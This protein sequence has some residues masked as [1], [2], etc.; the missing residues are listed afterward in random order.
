MIRDIDRY[1]PQSLLNQSNQFRSISHSHP[2]RDLKY[3]PY[4]PTRSMVGAAPPTMGRSSQRRRRR[5]AA[6]STSATT[7]ASTG[8]LLLLL[9]CLAWAPALPTGT[10]APLLKQ[11]LCIRLDPT[12]P[13]RSI[14]SDP[15]P[16][17]PIIPSPIYPSRRLLPRPIPRPNC[18]PRRC[19][20]P[21]CSPAPPRPE[22]APPPRR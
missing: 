12:V 17:T 7:S 14:N 5:T 3:L 20:R 6:A 10:C 15:P 11:Q 4:R 21:R 9:H 13:I 1:G 19:P 22:E 2:Q 18:P 8:L 16:Q